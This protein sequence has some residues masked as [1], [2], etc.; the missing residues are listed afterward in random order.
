VDVVDSKLEAY[1]VESTVND[2]DDIAG[3]EEKV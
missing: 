2:E 3:I 1:T